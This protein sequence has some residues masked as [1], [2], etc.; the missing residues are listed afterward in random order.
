MW[1]RER[2]PLGVPW[3]YVT[4]VD[5]ARNGESVARN[6]FFFFVPLHCR[7]AKGE[8]GAR[9][10]CAGVH[11]AMME[12]GDRLATQDSS[13]DS[14]RLD[15]GAHSTGYRGVCWRRSQERPGPGSLNRVKTSDRPM[16]VHHFLSKG[17]KNPQT[18][19]MWIPGLE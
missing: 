10:D 12:G 8:G 16:T 1:V 19:N 4:G 11:F 6:F 17:G 13:Q 15:R 3:V 14:P 9:W 2:C 18:G 7:L 5:G